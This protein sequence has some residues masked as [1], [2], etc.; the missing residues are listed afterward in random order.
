MTKKLAIAT[1][2][3]FVY[4]TL[5]GFVA[6]GLALEGLYQ[7]M[8]S[9]MRTQEEASGLMLWIYAAYLLQAYVLSAFYLKLGGGGLADGLKFGVMAGVLVG[10]VML[11][12]YSVYPY[13]LQ[14]SLTLFLTDVL[15]YAGAGLVLAL[16]VSRLK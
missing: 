12:Q 8:A 1:I 13:T 3:A 2:A 9:M 10:A 14:Q 11:I 16:T 6:H 4:L 5:F 15:H 7:G